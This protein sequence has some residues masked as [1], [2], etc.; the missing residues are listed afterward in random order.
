MPA[1]RLD[2]RPIRCLRLDRYDSRVVLQNARQIYFRYLSEA[3]S[4]PEPFG[5]VLSPAGG[6]GRVVFERPLLLPEEQF[7][8]LEWIRSRPGPLRFTPR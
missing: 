7:I 5:I 3:P 6:Q 4:A 2:P 8:P 1:E